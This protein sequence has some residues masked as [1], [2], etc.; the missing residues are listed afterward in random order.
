MIQLKKHGD[1]DPILNNGK[2]ISIN[3]KSKN[4]INIVFQD[5]YLMLPIFLRRLCL[6]FNV[7][8]IKSYFPYLFNNI[9][10]TGVL[11]AISYW[12]D[13]SLDEYSLLLKKYTPSTKKYGGKTWDFK[14]QAIKYCN[15][16]C[17]ALHK[18]LCK[19]NELIYTEFNIGFHTQI[20][21][22]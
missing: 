22:Y 11:P 19:F 13:I 1:I 4:G 12:T 3:F 15:L 5:S 2:L 21:T 9:F 14:E 7:N 16:D 10:Y 6:A 8:S 20:L 17:K 18:V